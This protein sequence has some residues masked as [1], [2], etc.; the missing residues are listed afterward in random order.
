MYR[1][2][3]CQGGIPFTGFHDS[4]AGKSTLM[5]EPLL[6]QLM[7]KNRHPLQPWQIRR[8]VW[9]LTQLS[10]LE[11]ILGRQEVQVR[12]DQCPHVRRGL[13]DEP[14]SYIGDNESLPGYP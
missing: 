7:T 12:A 4:I 2:I 1:D 9:C 11:R 10:S 14:H 6:S 3:M 5:H 13:M 8:Y